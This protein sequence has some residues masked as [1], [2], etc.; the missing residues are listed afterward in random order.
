MVRNKMKEKKPVN[1]Q[2]SI[3]NYGSHRLLFRK[4]LDE[5]IKNKV[6]NVSFGNSLVIKYFELSKEG[7]VSARW[8]FKYKTEDKYG[9]KPCSLLIGFYPATSLDDASRICDEFY[10]AI[11]NGI[12][13]YKFRLDNLSRIFPYLTQQEVDDYS[14][15]ARLSGD[16][17][18]SIRFRPFDPL[19]AAK[20][21]GLA[22]LSD[23]PVFH[24]VEDNP[25]PK[26]TVAAPVINGTPVEPEAPAS[27]AAS[28]VGTN[29]HLSC[30][31]FDRLLTLIES[32]KPISPVELSMARHSL[33][34]GKRS[35]QIA[36]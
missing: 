5:A 17:G 18:D 15:R 2:R 14:S 34:V 21:T 10:G 8:Y 6:K 31:A 20:R 24:S 35:I 19:E 32:G 12:D 36:S 30:L 28:D 9:A 4:K 16:F 26:V 11:E 25:I 7:V 27:P 1:L 13:P 3:L 23:V 29:L 33:N 22:S